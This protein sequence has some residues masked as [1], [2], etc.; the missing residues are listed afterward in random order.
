MSKLVYSVR[1]LIFL[2]FLSFLPDAASSQSARNGLPAVIGPLT[3]V[4]SIEEKGE[5][6]S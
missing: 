2:L 1:F 3:L 5:S 6:F 4:K